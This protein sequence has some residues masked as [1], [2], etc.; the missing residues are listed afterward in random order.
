[1]RV[2]SMALLAYLIISA[3]LMSVII[4]GLSILALERYNE[5]I[6]FWA[7]LL[8]EPIMIRSGFSKSFTA[9]PSLRNSGLET[10]SKSIFVFWFSAMIFFTRSAVPTGTV[11]LLTTILYSFMYLPIAFAT[12]FTAVRSTCWC[13][14]LGVPTQMK[15]MS[16]SRIDFIVSVVTWSLP[17]LRFLLYISSRPGSY[18]GILPFASRSTFSSSISWQMTSLPRFANPA[19][20]TRPTYPVPATVN[21]I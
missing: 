4:I 13:L 2:A 6:I 9:A 7:F 8:S 16:D 14:L 15:I 11:L 19:P 5:V 18:I 20:V 21:F 12:P 17:D 3:L 1:M 10:T